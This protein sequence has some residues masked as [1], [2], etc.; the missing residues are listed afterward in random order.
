M[1]KLF[2]AAA[3]AGVA[4]SLFAQAQPLST[5]VDTSSDGR[6]RTCGLHGDAD[7]V[8]DHLADLWRRCGRTD[9]GN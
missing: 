3:T 2:T 7:G 4:L 8:T 5:A 9:D 1:T 6:Y